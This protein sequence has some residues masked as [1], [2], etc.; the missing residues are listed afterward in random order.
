MAASPKPT[1]PSRAPPAGTDP[2]KYFNETLR[3]PESPPRFEMTTRRRA[4]GRR[5]GAARGRS[6]SR[7]KGEGGTRAARERAARP[8]A[9]VAARLG[10]IDGLVPELPVLL[11]AADAAAAP[12]VR[13]VAGRRDPA[14]RRRPAR[15]RGR[16]GQVARRVQPVPAGARIKAGSGAAATWIVRGDEG[17]G[18]ARTFRGDGSRP[19]PRPRR[20]HF[21]RRVA[22]L[23]RPRCRW[24]VETSRGDA[25]VAR[26]RAA[27]RPR[28]RRKRSAETS[29]GGVAAAMRIVRAD[30]CHGDARTFRG[31]G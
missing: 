21:V 23:P 25:D 15:G 24:S 18:D 29:C 19:R 17:R 4:R 7:V 1:S 27:A 5:R 12:A 28:P 31:D 16:R 6:C 13:H 3:A 20:K 8:Q 26:R 22:A 14:R 2:E 11:E 30:E 10:R 9:R